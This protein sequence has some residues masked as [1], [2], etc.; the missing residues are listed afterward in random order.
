[1][2]H[3]LL[4]SKRDVQGRRLA[5]VWNVFVQILLPLI[6]VLSFMIMLSIAQ[7]KKGFDERGTTIQD[8]TR[9]IK[10][11][12]DR[13]EF[14]ERRQHREQLL[15]IQWQKLELALELVI[16][17]KRQELGLGR[18]PDAKA[19]ALVGSEVR[20]EQFKSLCENAVAIRDVAKFKT[21]LFESILSQ[22]GVD[23][24]LAHSPSGA[25]VAGYETQPR[26]VSKE[27][28]E[29]L[30]QQLQQRVDGLFSDVQRIQHEVLTRVFEEK[31][32]T[33]EAQDAKILEFFRRVNDPRNSAENQSEAARAMVRYLNDKI[34]KSLEV[35]GYKLLDKTWESINQ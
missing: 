30:S 14:Q 12:V 25:T 6:L 19:V 5:D 24:P 28:G 29:K 11:L 21:Q 10:G 31:L 16:N 2:K 20:D 7:F 33:P 22:A 3:R 1:M 15:D 9:E 4:V 32:A 27:N 13:N 17:K 26:V 34:R 18:V 35:G 8:L 23:K